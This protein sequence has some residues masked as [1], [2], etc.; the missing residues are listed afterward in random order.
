MTNTPEYNLPKDA[1]VNFDALTLKSFMINQLNESGKFTDQN[2]EGSNISSL[3]DILAYYTHVLMF[4][5]NQT[6]TESMFSQATIYE[7]MNKIVK[8]IGYKPTG[9]QT[10]AVSINCVASN[11]LTPGNYSIKKYSYFLIDN[12]QY[13]FND[14]LF[15]EKVTTGS[16]NINSI[17]NNAIL[18]QGVVGEYPLYTATGI[19]YETIPV[20]VDNLVDNNDTR[21]ISHGSISVYVKEIATN[22]WVEYEEVDSLFLASDDSR[23]YDIRLNENGHYE[24]KFGNGIFGKSLSEDDEVAIFYI[25]SDGQKGQISKNAING[26]KIYIYNSSL[27]NQIYSDVN[28]SNINY[29]IDENNKSYLTFNNL[30]NSTIIRDAETVDEIR[31]N[32]PLFLSSQLRLVTELDYENFL[33][34]SIPNVLNDVKVV[35]NAV[36]MNEYIKYFYDICVDPNKVNRVILN[37]VN[38]ADSCDFNNINIYCV[39]SFNIV[40]D[41]QYPEFLSNSF[42]T[43]IKN[44]TKD[45]KIISN[46]VVPRDPIYMGID[47]GFTN[48]DIVSKN[49]YSD[50]KLV[51]VREQNNKTNKETLKSK[52]AS[53]ILQYFTPSN[54]K[55][56]QTIDISKLSS[57]IL[58]IAGVKNIRTINSKEN[59]YFNGLSLVMWNPMFENVDETVINQTT[60]LPF[61]KFP[62]IYRP[63]TLI[64]RIEV[65]DE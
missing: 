20:V 6:S 52:V 11:L 19:A 13:T 15:F 3:L 4:Y 64:N 43:L 63:N 23:V 26:N 8:L 35:D 31:E 33:K 36:Y 9:K 56:G 47:L 28:S 2:Y 57:D 58:S 22:T 62:Y 14:S 42:K 1:Y 49:I 18:Q 12:I 24:I 21:F 51:V 25:L 44:I 45:K 61:F 50:T 30:S 5:L 60:T 10:S 53:A 27:F 37:Q 16:E 40:S 65:I 17:S 38:F 48:L 29:D 54:I 41:D 55:L 59:V 46:E 34:K 32:S 39:P 7:N